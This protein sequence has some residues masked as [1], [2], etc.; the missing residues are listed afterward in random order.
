MHTNTTFKLKNSR[1]DEDF[2][3]WNE[4]MSRSFNQE[5]YYKHS[6]PLIIWVEKKRLNSISKLIKKELQETKLID[7]NI[8]EVGCG[9]GHVLE[10]ISSKIKT[11]NL[12]GLDPLE[13]WLE[14]A[15]AK[16]GTKARLIKGFAEDLPFDN[17]SMDIV[18]CSEVLEHVIDPQIVLNQLK[19]VIKPDGL[20]IVSIP[21]DRL[22]DT[23]KETLDIFKLY[24]KFFPKIQKD[25]QWHIHSFSLTLLKQFLPTDLKT[26][27][28]ITIPSPLLPLRY[29]VSLRK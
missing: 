22:I 5:F 26:Q 19:R 3:E 29:T 13:N 24:N 12:F 15:K 10:E 21:N 2:I 18:I 16:L 11:K 28:I 14:K 6:N 27:K 25:N 9:E 8:L 23:L 20:I 4:K 1:P 7:P 17:N